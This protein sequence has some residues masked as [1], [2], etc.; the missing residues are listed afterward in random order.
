MGTNNT[1]QQ[2]DNI[3]KDIKDTFI[4]NAEQRIDWY[5][6]IFVE[7][8]SKVLSLLIAIFIISILAL[9]FLGYLGLLLGFLFS[10][11]FNSNILGFGLVTLILLLILVVVVIFRKKLIEKPITNSIIRIIFDKNA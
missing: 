1:N 10:G 9:L 2:E 8:S 3:F 11:L 5:K 4:K 7:K 6:I